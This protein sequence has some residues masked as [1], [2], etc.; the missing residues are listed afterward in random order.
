MHRKKHKDPSQTYFGFYGGGLTNFDFIVGQRLA[1]DH[2]LDKKICPRD[3][4]PNENSLYHL[5][6]LGVGDGHL[7]DLQRDVVSLCQGYT[8]A[9]GVR[10]WNITVAE[11][12]RVRPSAGW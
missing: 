2:I 6:K 8:S 11:T 9:V 10:L 5:L 7:S 1:M 12:N 3:M 4:N